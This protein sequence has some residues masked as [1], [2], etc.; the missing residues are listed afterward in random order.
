MKILSILSLS[1][2]LFLTCKVMT[3]TYRSDGFGGQYQNI[4]YCA[5][6]AERKKLPFYYT[7]FTGME[8]N[9]LNQNDFLE[10]KEI[11]IGFKTNIPIYENQK[12]INVNRDTVFRFV[13]NRTDFLAKSN[14]LK[15]I[16]KIFYESKQ[17]T[18]YLDDRFFNV[19]VHV[20]RNLIDDSRSVANDDEII[21]KTINSIRKNQKYFNKPIKFHIISCGVGLK[22]KNYEQ[23][24]NIFVGEDIV[25]HLENEVETDFAIMVFSDILVSARSSLS[26]TAGL[27]SN[28]LILQIPFWHDPL[29]QNNWITLPI[30]RPSKIFSKCLER[31]LDRYFKLQT[32]S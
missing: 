15:K 17:K 10:R 4:I 16:K 9:Y 24:K 29:P 18:D 7:P 12:K 14:A 5:V 19:A 27:I 30:N 26:Y 21:N 23:F 1:K 2:T 13:S 20:R 28:N 25:F 3:N 11:F 22:D 31:L 32:R 6:Y 8:H